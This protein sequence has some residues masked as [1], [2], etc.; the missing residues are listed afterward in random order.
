MKIIA[1]LELYADKDCPD[2]EDHDYD[3][4]PYCQARHAINEIG[5]IAEE[6][7]KKINMMAKKENYIS[8]PWWQLG[9]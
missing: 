3:N 4:C 6:Y 9:R 7:L 2:D 5:E 1:E 8:Q